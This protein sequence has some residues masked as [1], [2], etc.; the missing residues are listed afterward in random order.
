MVA[1]DDTLWR[2]RRK[3]GKKN[4]FEVFAFIDPNREE[5]EIITGHF[6]SRKRA[7]EFADAMNA[8][9][10]KKGAVQNV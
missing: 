6:D 3:P 10:M 8:M 2:V 4:F 1:R 9:R 7:Q 5:I